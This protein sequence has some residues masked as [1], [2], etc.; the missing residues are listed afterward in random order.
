MK[1]TLDQALRKAA[2]LALKGRKGDAENLYRAVLR[3]FPDNPRAAAGLQGLS[4]PAQDASPRGDLPRNETER[5]LALSGGTDPQA[6]LDA[7]QALMPRY[8]GAPLLANVAGVAQAQ[9]G[10]FE[11]A[12]ASFARVRELQPGDAMVHRNLGNALR[13]V[14]RLDEAVASFD[15]ALE[16]APAMVDAQI[17]RGNCCKELGRLDE[18]LDSFDRALALQADQAGV[19]YNRGNVLLELG[20]LDEAL[21]SYD[22]TIALAPDWAEAHNNRGNLLREHDRLDEA[23]AS[24]DT[25]LRLKPD[26]GS[27]HNNRAVALK[28]LKR[29]DEAL[30]ASERAVECEADFNA[31]NNRGVVLV[32]LKRLEE[33]LVC[34]DSAA[35][36]KPDSAAVYNN[37][38]NALQDLGRFEEAIA[39]YDA[40]IRVS[41]ELVDAYGNRG[42]ALDKLGR[43]VEAI[44][45]Y[46]IALGLRPDLDSVRALML[47]QKAHI[48]DW[49]D[50]PQDAELARLGIDGD[51]VGPF[52]MLAADDHPARQLARARTWARTRMPATRPPLPKPAGRPEKLKIGYFSADYHAHAVMCLAARLFEV[53]DRARFELHAFSYGPDTRD[54][55][56]A[57]AVAAFDTF[58]PIGQLGDEAAAGLAREMGI[59]IAVDLSGYTRGAKTG[60]FAH[61]AAPVQ[62]NYLGYPGSMG[63]DFIDYIVADG[64]V[65][66]A[67]ARQ[68]YDEKVITL[69]HSYQAND[70]KRGIA[71]RNFT[72][73]ELG[74]PAQGFVFCCFNANYKISP[75][76]F[77]V[78]TRLLQRLEG[79]V[80]W[81][82]ESNATAR[83]N[84]TR[85]AEARGI[86]PARLVFAPRMHAGDHLARHRA[87]DLFLDTFNYNAHTTG[88]DAL[89][90]GLP[91]VTRLG[92][93]FAARVGASLLEATGL[94]ELVTHST[95]AYEELALALAA[96]PARLAA[97]RAR[98]AAGLPSA[99]LFDSEGFARDLERAYDVAFARRVAGLPPDHIDVAAERLGAAAEAAM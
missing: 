3:R 93:S 86:D 42:N 74:L 90:A 22:Q 64:V 45:S 27:A 50:V 19:W 62:M 58:N 14:A 35:R 77:D 30:A 37:A 21:D 94:G 67:A 31:Y 72:R 95:A 88:S 55:M 79:S 33:A 12:I 80:L 6:A 40:A 48:C 69:P 82:L 89:W 24:F 59:D 36:L 63:A 5:L 32:E 4:A 46:Q 68:F 83:A 16:L 70:N 29:L 18:A 78:W 99:P 56:R 2:T 49:S 92:E 8:P 98:L 43:P 52:T 76:E 11:E 85:E 17:S 66:P 39:C 96:D 23:L 54:G 91:I 20:R 51:G 75:A 71:N 1:L 25:A 9:L 65:L 38:G 97:I 28:D 61:R 47:Y 7:A 10:R 13:S 84:L 41:P 87:A 81:L 73:A 60:V 53:H 44:A 34:F 26:L 57:R 15:A